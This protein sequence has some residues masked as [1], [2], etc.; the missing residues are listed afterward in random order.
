MN[1]F[2]TILIAVLVFGFLILIHEFGHYIFA[3]IFGVTVKEFSI[4]MGPKLLWYD[5]KKTG[6]RYT[7]AALPL[8]GF[9]SMAGEDEESDDPNA[10]NKK[11]AWQRFIIT[12]AGATVNIVA[13]LLAMILL[14]SIVPK[15]GTTPLG[16]TVVHSFIENEQLS[17]SSKE[18]GLMVGDKITRVNGKRVTILDELSYEIMRGGNKPIDLEVERDGKVIELEDVVFPTAVEQEQTF[19]MMDFRVW[20]EAQTFGSVLSYSLKKSVLIVRMCWESIFDLITGRYTLAAVSGPVGISSAIGD[21]ARAGASTLLYMVALISIN[22][23]VMNLL[24]LPALD[25]GRLIC[26]MIEMITRKKIPAK[27]ESM[28]HGIGLLLLLGLS[29]VILFKDIFQL[30][31]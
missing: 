24:P 5:S 1:T 10:F 20:G 30:V 31:G 13:G 19:G 27:I 25:G 17:H 26:L 3:R 9:V 12:A 29:V 2:T 6:I 23:G 8:G 18:Y 4:G 15:D 16:G 22:L 28:I 21:A 14:C 11:P 7:I